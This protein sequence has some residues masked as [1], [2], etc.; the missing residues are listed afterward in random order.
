MATTTRWCDC[1][2]YSHTPF[3][4][5]FKTIDQS[6]IEPNSGSGRA[7]KELEKRKVKEDDGLTKFSTL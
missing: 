2:D 5:S 7:I 3:S 1:T 4:E 6:K